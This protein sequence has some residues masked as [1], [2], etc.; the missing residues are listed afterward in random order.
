MK[1]ESLLRDSFFVDLKLTSCC[2]LGLYTGFQW[3]PVGGNM[4]EIKEKF[5]FG[6]MRL[7]L[8]DVL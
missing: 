8:K 7:P 6:M 1:D 4:S 5:D 2:I 3:K